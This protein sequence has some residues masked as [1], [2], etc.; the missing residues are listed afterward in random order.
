MYNVSSTAE[1]FN[2]LNNKL[3]VTTPQNHLILMFFLLDYTLHIH[4]ILNS[5]NSKG[6]ISLSF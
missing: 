5:D 1:S 2:Q 4:V 3:N 6:D